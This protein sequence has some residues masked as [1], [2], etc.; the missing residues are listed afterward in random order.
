MNDLISFHKINSLEQL[1]EISKTEKKMLISNLNS[2][3][4]YHFM[5]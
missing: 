4:N 3:S 2:Y 1:Y 5:F